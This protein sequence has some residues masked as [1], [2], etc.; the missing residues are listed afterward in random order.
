[1]GTGCR[2]RRHSGVPSW[3]LDLH[4]AKVNPHLTK[5]DKADSSLPWGSAGS[6]PNVT[7]LGEKQLLIF[8]LVSLWSL[9]LC[10]DTNK[11]HTW[12]QGAPAWLK[13]SFK[14]EKDPFNAA[15]MKDAPGSTLTFD[16][17]FYFSIFDVWVAVN[18]VRSS[19]LRNSPLLV[20]L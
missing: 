15:D 11:T 8:P 6:F 4:T 2:S 17:G 12:C 16:G 18:S 19:G 1:M 9:W 13:G 7:Q 14:E 10:R 3:S 5:A 20:T